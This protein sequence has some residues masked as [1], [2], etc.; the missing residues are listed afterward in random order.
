MARMAGTAVR[1]P[2][3]PDGPKI[4]AYAEGNPADYEDLMTSIFNSIVSAPFVRLAK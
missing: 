3:N 1:D 2:N 4:S